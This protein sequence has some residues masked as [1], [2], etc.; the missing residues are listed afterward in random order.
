M[1]LILLAPWL[2]FIE[3]RALDVLY[4]LAPTRQPDPRVEI[5][6]IGDDPAPYEY[7][8][9]PRDS[10]TD[11]CEVPREAYAE[12]VRRLNRWGA[13]VI[14]FDLMFRRRCEYEDDELAAAFRQAGN[15]I[16]AATTQT[17]P[18]AVGLQDPV[19]PLQDAV[20]AV[21]SPVAHQ[22][23]ETVRSVP[24]VVRDHDTGRE[25][26]ALSLLAF[27]RFMGVKPSETRLSEGRW[28][29]TAGRKVP[30][31]TGER[32]SLLPLG[33]ASD[34]DD[35]EQSAIAA[36]E[37]VRGSDVELIPGLKTWNS[38]LVN[39]AGPQG[40]IR[41]H[42]L[43]E[44]LAID[45]DARGREL[46]EG[47]AII[48]G[49]EEWD[50]HWTAMGAMPGLE[51]QGNALQTLLSGAFIR[52]MSPWAMLA[53]TALFAFATASG[54]RWLRGARAVGVV[55]VLTVA[56]VILA[57]QLLVQ[58]GIWMYVF[59][60][61]LGIWLAWGMTT[62]AESDK[63]TALLG[64]FVP[65]FMGKAEAPRLGEVRTLDASILFSDIRGYSS[66]AEQLSAADT[67]TML[68]SYHSAV[69]DIIAEHGGTIVKTPGDAVLAVFWQ[70]RKG[71]SHAACALRAGRE[72]L[73]D[74]PVH[75]REWE[76]A[77]VRLEIG[78]GIN[79]GP[80][81]IGLV[82][83]RHLEPTV[84]GD[85]VNVAQRLEDLTK[86]LGYPLIF[87]ESVHER[88]GEDVEATCLDEVILKGRKTPIRV[89]GWVCPEN[90]GQMPE[91]G[92]DRGN[93][94]SSE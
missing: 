25:Y 71:V 26:L 43:S 94:E 69:E 81:A 51:V 18:G 73:A 12:A 88:L 30:L 9:D 70:E 14:A 35:S 86:S 79:A 67:L 64:R 37:V 60:C 89:Y 15:V 4:A 55:F 49:R 42:G 6:D 13:G 24:L 83:K 53:V 29:L 17:R 23:N 7:L 68:H 10:P 22:P 21:G 16:V 45:D 84:I 31:L 52:P 91:R 78:V 72:I 19:P 20:W 80:V 75:A 34:A 54:V 39:W 47:K 27:Q 44:V 90:L 3:V 33:V 57:R 87:S 63:V 56:A 74:L 41:P 93:K 50:V 1:L 66:T 76:A 48:I 8:R 38:L 46:F 32:I 77:G 28:L 59:Y 2:T 85:P 11:G 40:T 65:S 61:A 58:Q 82:G 36:V 62:V 5:I 92:A